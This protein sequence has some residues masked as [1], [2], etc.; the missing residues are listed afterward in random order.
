MRQKLQQWGVCKPE[1]EDEEDGEGEMGAEMR[2]IM[3]HSKLLHDLEALIHV[4]LGRH[5][6]GRRLCVAAPAEG[7]KGR[8][9][10][11]Q[12]QW[13]SHAGRGRTKKN[14]PRTR[15]GRPASKPN[16]KTWFLGLTFYVPKQTPTQFIRHVLTPC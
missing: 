9:S 10:N 3:V 6:G 2:C 1:E 5:R 7:R 11:C 4:V 8:S 12:R 16:K 15:T 14:R 13:R